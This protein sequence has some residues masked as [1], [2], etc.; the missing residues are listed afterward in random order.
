MKTTSQHSLDLLAQ[1]PGTINNLIDQMQLTDYASKNKNHVLLPSHPHLAYLEEKIKE[2]EGGADAL[3]LKSLTVA[4][5]LLFKTL[6][7]PGDNVVSYNSWSLYFNDEPTYKNSG[8]S[9]RLSVDGRIETMEELIDDRTRIIYLETMSSEFLNIPDFKRISAIARQKNIPLVVDNTAGGPGYL[10]S[11][12][13][14]GANIVLLDTEPWLLHNNKEYAGAAII[15]DSFYQ[16]NNPLFAHLFENNSAKLPPNTSILSFIRQSPLVKNVELTISPDW[17]YDLENVDYILFRQSENAALLSSWLKQQKA[18]KYVHYLGFPDNENYLLASSFFKKG[19]GN[20]FSF[21]LADGKNS[22][23]RLIKKVRELE[24]P[25]YLFRMYFDTDIAS[26]VV[27]TGYGDIESAK[28]FMKAILESSHATSAPS[29][30]QY[31]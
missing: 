11:P 16:W 9:I 22:F 23:D 6:L 26:I 29:T 12:I 15:E 1:S 25:P 28:R 30:S 3:V 27:S 19:F 18:V 2:M 8:I 17:H 7:R 24:I 20:T 14:Y 10:T 21:K 31:W 4:R 5:Y 13:R